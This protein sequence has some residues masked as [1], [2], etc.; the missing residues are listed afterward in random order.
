MLVMREGY[1][2][3]Y[4]QK[5]SLLLFYFGLANQLLELIGFCFITPS[6]SLGSFNG[7]K[8]QQP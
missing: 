7:S 4:Q 5:L 1:K 6:L 3:S 2:E 8:L